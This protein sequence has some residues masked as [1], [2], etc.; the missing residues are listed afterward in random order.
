MTELTFKV[1]VDGE[2]VD[3]TVIDVKTEEIKA[4]ETVM[5]ENFETPF[6]ALTRVFDDSCPG[7]TKDPEYN[8]MF[9]DRQ[10][11]YMTEK[12]RYKKY[13]L[14]NDVYDQLGFPRTKAGCVMG[15]VYDENKPNGNAVDFGILHECNR[16]FVNGYDRVCILE[17]NIDGNVFEL[18]D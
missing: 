11:V 13:L 14:L 4:V 3:V 9:L 1:V 6:G 8:R 10:Q 16:N 18:M 5:V 15:W 7:W 2:K 17:F 12:L